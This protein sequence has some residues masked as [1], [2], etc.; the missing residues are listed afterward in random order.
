M[1]KVLGFLKLIRPVNCLMTGV[2]VII[3]AS[4][5]G[6]EAT[7]SDV[8]WRLLLGFI[9]AF[10]FTGASMAIN[11]YYDREI[12]AINEPSHPIPSG[13]V[14]PK[15]SLVLAALL[16]V[17]GLIAAIFTNLP[18]LM[19]AVMVWLMMMTYNTGGKRTGLPGNLLV[20]ACVA[21]SFI[22]GS[23]ILLE[24]VEPLSLIFA[25]LAFLAIAGRE[26]NKGMVDVVGDRSKNVRTIA[27]SYGEKAAAYLASV[28]YLS[29][30]CLSVLPSI[31]NFV[32]VW[33]LPFVAVTDVGFIS[34]SFMLIRNQSRENARKVKNLAL[35]WMSIA[36]IA[37]IIGVSVGHG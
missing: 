18:S 6:V 35:I 33:Y 20:S 29:A 27:V 30:V 13:I 10:T 9:T 15:E 23:L 28:F 4:L 22:Y 17:V 16:T 7:A 12:D 2:A 11:D 31:F 32:S 36:L 21:A 34:S 14:S 19:V 5:V 8:G 37:F 1:K 25:V 3:G 26:I 24:R